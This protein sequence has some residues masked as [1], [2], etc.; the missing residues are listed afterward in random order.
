MKWSGHATC[1]VEM[2]DIRAEGK[3]QFQDW[4]R[5]SVMFRLINIG[6]KDANF[7][8][9]ITLF[10]QNWGLLG[11]GVVSSVTFQNTGMLSI[12]LALD[13]EKW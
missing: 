9:L 5:Q 1:V 4:H 13:S 11:L 8:I 3:D 12:L 7:E 2:R 10:L 6:W